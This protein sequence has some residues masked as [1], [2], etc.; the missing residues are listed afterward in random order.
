MECIVLS[1]DK[2]TFV[3]TLL[4]DMTTTSYV[5]NSET[6]HCISGPF[7]LKESNYLWDTGVLDACF[8]PNR[9]HILVIFRMP[10]FHY[11]VVWEIERGEKVSQI[12]GRIV[13][14][15]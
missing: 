7:E 10:L 4:W 2:K 9:K 15:D 6:G 1:P 12:E 11:A 13:S 8:S 3:S 5:C 14:V